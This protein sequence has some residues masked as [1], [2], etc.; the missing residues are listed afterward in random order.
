MQFV[1]E[2]KIERNEKLLGQVEP[3]FS[4]SSRVTWSE[5]ERAA[6]NLNYFLKNVNVKP[7][8]RY[9]YTAL[10]ITDK[11]GRMKGTLIAGLTTREARDWMDAMAHLLRYEQA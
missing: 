8:R 9:G 2:K 11:A 7:G 10:D 5:V 4:G 6:D 1:K 3:S